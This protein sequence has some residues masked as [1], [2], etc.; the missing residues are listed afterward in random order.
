VSERPLRLL[1]VEDQPVN[2]ALL[3]AVLSRATDSPLHAAQL[4]VATSLAEARAVLQRSAFD[5]VLLDVGLP[6]GNGL[7]LMTDIGA[8]APRPRVLVLTASAL[9]ADEA[10]ARD[11]GA[12]AFLAKP[13]EPRTL[14]T[15]LHSLSG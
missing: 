4:T 10:A 5:L 3:R 11:W 9:P 2:V 1:A 14:L 8:H 7:E 13:Y 6:D 15:A 12:D